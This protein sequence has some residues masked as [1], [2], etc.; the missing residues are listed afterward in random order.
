MP[1]KSN[2]KSVEHYP[3]DLRDR[4]GYMKERAPMVSVGERWFHVA[5][6]GAIA[7]ALLVG[8]VVATFPPLANALP[9]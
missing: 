4:R 8:K 1:N 7:A 9:G 3:Q 2:E 5:V 6:I